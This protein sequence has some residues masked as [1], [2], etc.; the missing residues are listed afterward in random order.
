M[1]STESYTYRTTLTSSEI[2]ELVGFQPAAPAL[3]RMMDVYRTAKDYVDNHEHGALTS[4]V[5]CYDA[6]RIAVV[7]ATLYGQPSKPLIPATLSGQQG[8]AVPAGDL[9]G[10]KR[11]LQILRHPNAGMEPPDGGSPSQTDRVRNV[12]EEIEE[13]I[14]GL[15]EQPAPAGTPIDPEM[16]LPCDVRVAPATIIRKGVPVRTLLLS[17]KQR[18]GRPERD[19]RFPESAPAGPG[20]AGRA[21]GLRP[22][23]ERALEIV[24]AT[25]H[26]SESPDESVR[27]TVITNAICAELDPPGV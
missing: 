2:A 16:P 11:A 9:P 13:L 18:V 8:G 22:G 10:L 14:A 19:T 1:G 26:D 20:D 4:R 23:L 12:A 5:E 7:N 6:L 25:R 15:A 17:L 21:E 27:T 24:K 3:S